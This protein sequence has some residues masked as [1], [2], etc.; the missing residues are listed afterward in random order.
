LTFFEKG[1]KM[2]MIFKTFKTV[3]YCALITF[4]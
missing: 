4:V 1:N 2:G 3:F